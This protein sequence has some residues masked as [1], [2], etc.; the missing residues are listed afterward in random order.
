[1]EDDGGGGGGGFNQEASR[2]R[3]EVTSGLRGFLS[4]QQVGNKIICFSLIFLLLCFYFSLFFLDFPLVFSLTP[5]YCISMF[6]LSIY[7]KNYIGSVTVGCEP[8]QSS[9]CA[10]GGSPNV[11]RVSSRKTLES[12]GFGFFWEGVQGNGC[13]ILKRDMW[14]T[15]IAP[16]RGV[17]HDRSCALK[18]KFPPAVTIPMN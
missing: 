13:H 7:F 16:I 3:G 8:H 11:V 2:D 17:N 6:F 9:G 12:N 4:I 10:L 14:L 15:I 18:W 1:M 5:F